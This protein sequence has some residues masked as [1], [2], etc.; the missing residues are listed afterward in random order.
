MGPR[1]IA[2]I[3][4]AC[5]EGGHAGVGPRHFRPR[6][7]T[8]VGSSTSGHPLSRTWHLGSDPAVLP[9]S[10]QHRQPSNRLALRHNG[11]TRSGPN[12]LSNPDDVM[13]MPGSQI[14]LADLDAGLITVDRAWNIVGHRIQ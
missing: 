12:Q 1:R 2:V 13:M 7:R 4:A 5:G 14:I 3:A 11:R 10:I 6:E 8:L 9:S